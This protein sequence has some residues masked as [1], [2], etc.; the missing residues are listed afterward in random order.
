MET[1]LHGAELQRAHGKEMQRSFFMQSLE[2]NKES[3]RM[4]M[5]ALTSAARLDFVQVL[6]HFLAMYWEIP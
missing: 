6:F 4:Q 1:G 3:V 2:K 5:S